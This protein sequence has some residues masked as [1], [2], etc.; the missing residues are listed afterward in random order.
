MVFNNLNIAFPEKSK[1]EKTNSGFRVLGYDENGFNDCEYIV[2]ETSIFTMGTDVKEK[3]FRYPN[4]KKKKVERYNDD[5]LNGWTDN[6]DEKGK[7]VSSQRYKFGALVWSTD[8]KYKP[9]K[10]NVDADSLNKLRTD[11][12]TS[13]NKVYAMA[14]KMSVKEVESKAEQIA[15]LQKQYDELVKQMSVIEKQIGR[16]SCRERV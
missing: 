5:K 7:K 10:S 4:G 2:K 14:G 16:A 13:V 8:Y 6:Y 12:N 11:L 9:L 15:V 3:V 1:A